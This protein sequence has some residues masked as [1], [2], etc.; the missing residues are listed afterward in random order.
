MAVSN[1]DLL[2]ADKLGDGG[3]DCSVGFA[4]FQARERI[5]LQEKGPA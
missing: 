2:Q 5:A 4:I 1:V 3:A